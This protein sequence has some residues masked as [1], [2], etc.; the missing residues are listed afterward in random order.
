MFQSLLHARYRALVAT[1][2]VLILTYGT[3]IAV[4]MHWVGVHARAITDTVAI[5]QADRQAKQLAGELQTFRLLPLVLSEYPDVHTVLAGGG[6]DAAARLN[7]KLELLAQRTG[8][9][10]IYVIRSDGLTLASSNWRTPGSFVGSNFSFRPYFRDALKNGEAEIFAIGTV[11][12]TPGLFIA[13]RVGSSAKP[14]GVIVVKIEFDDLETLWERK[15]GSTLVLD[16]MGVII[17]TDKDSWRF[18]AIRPVTP[19]ERA[20]L[21]K[22]LLFNTQPLVP[23]GWKTNTNGDVTTPDQNGQFRAATVPT[24]LKGA[25]LVYLESLE[26]AR[27][28]LVANARLSAIAGFVVLASIFAAFWRFHMGKIAQ[29]RQREAL[30]TQVSLRTAELERANGR[31]R[32]ESRRRV[33]ADERLRVAREELA[34]ANRLGTIGQ[35]TAGIAHEVNQPVAAIRAFAE[36]ARR[37]LQRQDVLKVDAKLG[38]ILDLTD[39][40]GRIT[41]E[42]RS[43]ARR[44]AP[45][46][47]EAALGAAIEGAILLIADRAREERVRIV[48]PG[49]EHEISVIGD[50]TRLEQILIN[51]IQNALDALRDRPEPRIEIQVAIGK[52]VSVTIADNGP[53]VAP[54]MSGQLFTPFSTS[55]PDGLGLGLGIARDIAREFG[56]SLE[57]VPSPLCG[58]AFRVTLRPAP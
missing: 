2:V 40:I 39:R 7:G 10:A 44:G 19:A 53:G 47:G 37:Y 35:I 30:E 34:Q 6:A 48:W 54:D 12:G 36:N 42:L 25:R 22:T 23:L 3:A 31:L 21:Q 4:Q 52:T 45:V 55:K 41:T 17:I 32:A 16:P 24:T 49:L 46:V 9:L 50:K 1:A 43:F 20:E 27:S 8:A 11:T 38:D 51:L 5:D 13:E 14:L 15:S 33:A 26:P 29:A 18:R 56:G 28:R 57:L 58:A